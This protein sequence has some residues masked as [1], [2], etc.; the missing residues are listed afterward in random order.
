MENILLIRLSSLS[1]VRVW[2]LFLIVHALTPMDIQ[3]ARPNVVLILIDDLSHY[4]VTAYGA[5]RISEEKG[6]FK[7]RRFSTPNIDRLAYEG[8][9]CDQAFAY[10]LCEPT[11]IALMSG[12]YNSRN[13]LHCKSQHASDITFGDVFK[14]AGYATGIFGKWKQ[15]R[16]THETPGKDYLFEF[17]WDEFCCFDVVG[18]GQRFINPNLVIDGKVHNYRGRTDLDP[19][20]GRRWYG[21]DICNRRA[22]DFIHRNADRKDAKP[23]F[24]YYPMLLVHDEHKPTPDT[25]P[26]SMFDQCDE[27]TKNDDRRYFPDMLAYMDK[28]IGNVVNELAMHGLQ[29][30]TLVVVMGDNGTKEPF[31]HILSDGSLYPGGKGDTKDNG[32]HVPLIFSWQG[33]IPAG[34]SLSN[35]T[36]K[37]RSYNGLVDLT[38]IYPTLCDAAQIAVPNP[39][40]IDGISFWPQVLGKDD[41]KNE[42][43]STIYTWY[44]A[45]RPSTDQSKTLRYAFNKQFKRYAPHANF[46]EGRFFDLRTDLLERTGDRSATIAWGH[47]HHS[48]LDVR[49]LT[50]EQRAAYDQLGQVIEAHAHKPVSELRIRN[51]DL[52]LFRGQQKQLSVEILPEGATRQNVV[53][54]SSDSTIATVDKFGL[55]RAHTTGQVKVS[56]YSWEDAYPL[57]NNAR[58]EFSTG[59]I[60]DS[61]S[62]RI[63]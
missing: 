41:S 17:G 40:Q 2:L 60:S 46:P 10:P 16:G 44:N 63:Q 42:P 31:T 3:A 54:H 53:W 58:E 33:V 48:G 8:L 20:T 21:P 62:L 6:L 27:R 23:F 5:N 24:L 22:L 18:E 32:L 25:Q 43:R 28:L 37:I 29:N 39:K 45:N 12:Q 47:V 56:V 61:I 19:A 35:E 36:G 59:G 38:D 34:D 9:R 13:Y 57:A 55:I 51:R 4:G 1:T 14:R 11:R 30:K 52:S 7:N 49:K 50:A 26:Q 15:T